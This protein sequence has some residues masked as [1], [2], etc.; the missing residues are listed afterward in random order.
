MDPEGPLSAAWRAGDSTWSLTS[1]AELAEA[2][3]RVERMNAEGT[4]QAYLDQRENER[5]D[6]GQS[7]FVYGRKTSPS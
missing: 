2:M 3:Q 7:T 1:D 6:T 5:L 4:M